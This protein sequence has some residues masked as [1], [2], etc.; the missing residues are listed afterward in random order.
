MP[1]QSRRH[2]RDRDV[3]MP[4]PPC[5]PRGASTLLSATTHL[6]VSPFAPSPRQPPAL[7]P[8]P[9]PHSAVAVP[10]LCSALVTSGSLRCSPYCSE[11]RPLR[12]SPGNSCWV[13]RMQ[14]GAPAPG[15]FL[16]LPPCDGREPALWA[17]RPLP[18]LL[19]HLIA[20]AHRWE[21]PLR[22]LQAVG[23]WLACPVMYFSC[24]LHGLSKVGPWKMANRQTDRWRERI[25]ANALCKL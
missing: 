19:P 22:P 5:C 24:P 6:S 21:P 12:A 25:A 7:H 15:T 9:W 23:A 10:R 11:F 20:S 18:E 4:P 14:V 3:K 13:S 16:L 2:E 8:G 17:P 1:R